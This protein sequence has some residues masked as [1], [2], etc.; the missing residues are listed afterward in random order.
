MEE[1]EF[2]GK[3]FLPAP[4]EIKMYKWDL[5]DLNV[6]T[7]GW[8]QIKGATS[9]FIEAMAFL[10]NSRFFIGKECVCYILF[11]LGCE[12]IRG[13]LLLLARECLHCLRDVYQKR[14]RVGGSMV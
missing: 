2:L 9:K 4:F 13:D 5:K 12:I 8:I 6:C 11:Y 3:L 10:K 1:A 14:E 7:L